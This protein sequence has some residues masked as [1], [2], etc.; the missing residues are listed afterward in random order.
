MVIVSFLPRPTP[1]RVSLFARAGAFGGFRSQGD[2]AKTKKSAGSATSEARHSC[3]L[4]NV[5]SESS[6]RLFRIGT[7]RTVP[8][9]L[10]LCAL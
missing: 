5:E 3:F 6:F 7:N 9:R 10:Q 4:D 8:P 1:R 2:G